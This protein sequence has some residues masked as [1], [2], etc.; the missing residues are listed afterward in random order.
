MGAVMQSVADR[1]RRFIVDDLGWEGTGDELTDDLPL[2][3]AGA[4]DSIEILTLVQFLES[5]YGITVDDGEIVSVHLGS[6]ASIERY[7]L[8][9]R[10]PESS[11]SPEFSRL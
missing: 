10:S 4:I 11:L 2:I 3:H 5:N 8:F 6:L 9:K 1:V 7:V